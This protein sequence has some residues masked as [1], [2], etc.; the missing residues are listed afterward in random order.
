MGEDPNPGFGFLTFFFWKLPNIYKCCE[1]NELSCSIHHPASTVINI[2]PF[3]FHLSPDPIFFLEY[4]K[5]QPQILYHFSHFDFLFV[6]LT[7]EACPNQSQRGQEGSL[8]A[9]ASNLRS[10]GVGLAATWV[11]VT[12]QEE[13]GRKGQ[14]FQTEGRVC[15]EVKGEGN[16]TCLA[17]CH[18]P[19]VYGPA[20]LALSGSLL[21]L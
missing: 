12:G 6:A 5:N 2:L 9:V 4:F 7:N 18:S 3:L 14:T 16:V 10:G 11:K 15:A 21:E 8:E 19:V 20:E 17:L 13:E 1:H